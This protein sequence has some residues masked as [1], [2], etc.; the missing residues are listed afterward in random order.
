MPGRKSH[1][2]QYPLFERYR[3]GV[4][5][6]DPDAVAVPTRREKPHPARRR[7]GIGRRVDEGRPLPVEHQLA[8]GSAN[9]LNHYRLTAIGR[10][11]ERS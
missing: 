8:R 3:R 2:F 9:G 10:A 1:A 5:E 4:A 11:V 6:V 7:A